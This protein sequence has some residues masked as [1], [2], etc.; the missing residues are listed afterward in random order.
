MDMMTIRRRVM[1]Q[2]QGGERLPAEYQEVAWIASSGTQYIDSGIVGKP[3]VEVN[4]D[5]EYTALPNNANVGLL[6]SRNSG[7][8]F[9]LISVYNGKF[10]LGISG[11]KTST[12][13]A[14]TDTRYKYSMSYDGNDFY[15]V[16]ND[17]TILSGTQRNATTPYNLY[18]FACNNT[19]SVARQCSAKLYSMTIKIDGDTVRNLVPC[20]R[21]SDSVAGLYDLV[22]GEFLTNA[23]SGNFIIP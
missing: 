3:S 12:V 20:Y 13:T 14:L 15:A 10:H 22:E 1:M 8:R 16:V 6:G 21:K 9:Y 18:I 23:G 2:M 17:D 4:A 19:G 7:T 5:F 11:D